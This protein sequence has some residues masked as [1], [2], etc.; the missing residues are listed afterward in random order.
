MICLFTSGGGLLLE[1]KHTSMVGSLSQKLHRSLV[2][3]K[4][5][6]LLFLHIINSYLINYL[7]NL[8]QV[9]GVVAYQYMQV[10]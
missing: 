1:T 10:G 3:I 6:V 2:I 5:L 8:I 7:L 9:Q 4:G